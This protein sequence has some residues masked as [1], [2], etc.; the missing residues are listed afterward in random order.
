MVCVVSA[1]RVREVFLL[2][3]R[4]Q[5]PNHVL[6]S[7]IF[8]PAVIGSSGCSGGPCPTALYAYTRK[9]YA[10]PFLSPVT[11]MSVTG[12]V[13]SPTLVQAFLLDSLFS[14]V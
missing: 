6:Y 14:T 12:A 4:G 2:A 3:P 8:L 7:L 5:Y 11:S 9:K 10:V 13:V 1:E